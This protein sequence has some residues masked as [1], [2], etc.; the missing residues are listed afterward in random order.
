MSLQ[1]RGPDQ[2]AL[3]DDVQLPEPEDARLPRGVL[4]PGQAA[5]REVPGA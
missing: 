1:L 2:L 3:R 5:D 4:H